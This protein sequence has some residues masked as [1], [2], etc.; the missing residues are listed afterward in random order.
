MWY[1]IVRVKRVAWVLTLALG[2]AACKGVQKPPAD[3]AEKRRTESVSET[4]GITYV[5]S[6]SG[7]ITARLMARH[8]VERHDGGK[9]E[10]YHHLDKGF[11]LLSYG[12]DGTL[13]STIRAQ[14]GRL[15]QK[16]G[17]AEAIG[18]VVLR[19]SKG[20]SMETERLHWYR[21]Q[22]KIETGEPVKITTAEEIIFGEGFESNTNFT[23]YK[24]FKIRG[25]LQ[26][27]E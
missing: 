26:V 16:T 6:D 27:K 17:Y 12:P 2:L 3:L 5:Y 9:N 19:S 22:N 10:T 25:T 1:K 8:D 13:E 7:R 21:T 18:K 4:Y 23:R 20:D 24:I 11:I 15:F 14:E